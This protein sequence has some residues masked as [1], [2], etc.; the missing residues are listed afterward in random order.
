M[1]WLDIVD[2]YGNPTGE[3]VER[4]MAHARGI[5]HRTAHVWILRDRGDGTEV[6][7]QKRSRNKDSHPGC[8]DI[9]SAGHIPAGVDYLPSAIREL[10]EELGIDAAEEE[11][12][13]C[14]QRAII[15][16]EE[17]Y[18]KE[19]LDNQVSNIYCMWKDVRPCELHLQEAE[20]EEVRWIS[21]KECKE[22]V[23]NHTFPNCIR[24]EELEMLP[25]SLAEFID[26]SQRKETTGGKQ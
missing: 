20:V 6:L 22:A 17:F 15:W 4:E 21:L 3:T 23:R 14:G 1:E 5:R 26:A 10:K 11:I 13:Y 12:H 7:M 2:E 19:F 16:K 9:S 25:I 18:G 8:Y 24:L